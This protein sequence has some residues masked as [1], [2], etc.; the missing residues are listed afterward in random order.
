MQTCKALSSLCL[1]VT[2][3]AWSPPCLLCIRYSSMLLGVSSGK[4]LFIECAI[5]GT[6]YFFFFAFLGVETPNIYVHPSSLCLELPRK[7]CKQAST[8]ASLSSTHTSE[9][10]S[11][12]LSSLK[13]QSW[14]GNSVHLR[15]SVSLPLSPSPPPVI[16]SN[17]DGI[18]VGVLMFSCRNCT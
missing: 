17:P 5:P 7:H 6:S 13:G 11:S 14:G 8:P 2:P 1:G 12:C 18:K 4:C 16:A 10:C 9:T 3:R 15:D